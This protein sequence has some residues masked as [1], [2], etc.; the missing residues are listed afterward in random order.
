MHTEFCT[1]N[2]QRI[3]H[4]ITGISHIR[5]FNSFQMTKMLLNGQHVCDHL[6][7]MKLIGQTVPYRNSRIFCQV[8]HDCLLK[9]TVLDTVI[10]TSKYTGSICDTFFLSNLGCRR[11]Q[12]CGMHT[13]I[14]GGYFKRAAGTCAGF[15]KDQCNVF[16]SQHIMTNA[17]FLLFFE[18]C[19]QIDQ[20]CDLLRC[21][22]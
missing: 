2:H 16:S 19:G 12:K 15:F 9:S 20:I 10:H 11:I 5:K 6:C 7:R 4:I 18:F 1:Y 22:I 3:S 14:K 8:F 17:F 21:K 13:K